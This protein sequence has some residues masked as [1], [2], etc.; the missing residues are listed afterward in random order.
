V[1]PVHARNRAPRLAAPTRGLRRSAAAA[2]THVRR[3][4]VRAESRGRARL[5]PLAD[6]R[7]RARRRDARGPRTRRPLRKAHDALRPRLPAPAA[8]RRVLVLQAPQ[9]VPAGRAGG[10]LPPP[11]W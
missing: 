11:L 10:A 9:D 1:Q 2:P 6:R 7:L 3:R 8:A 4:L 5:L